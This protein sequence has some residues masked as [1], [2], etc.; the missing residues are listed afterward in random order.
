MCKILCVTNSSDCD[1]DFINHIDT[2]ARSDIYAIVLREKHLNEAEYREIA[3]KVLEV[4]N[5][6]NK[7]CIL[8]NYIDTAINLKHK[9]IHLPLFVLEKSADKLKNFDVIGA[10]VH[11]VEQ[12]VTAEKLG[13]TYIT[14]GHIFPTDCKK[15]LQPKGTKSIKEIL[16]TVNIT[17][18]PLGGIN[19]NNYKQVIAQEV[20]GFAVMSGLMKKGFEE[21]LEI[22]ANE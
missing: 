8:H 13:A 7:P 1:F 20:D 6:Y 22:S 14:Y 10:S 18:Y 19:L 11:S 21:Y 3:I 4:C 17:V 12:A 2:L 16:N 15:G 9:A 5:K